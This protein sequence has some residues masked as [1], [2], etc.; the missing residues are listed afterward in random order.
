MGTG[1][2]FF[3]RDRC[4]GQSGGPDTPA[5]DPAGLDLPNIRP[6]TGFDLPDIWPDTGFDLPETR[7][8]T[9]FDLP[10][11]WPDTGNRRLTMDTGTG[12]YRY[13]DS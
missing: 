8:D 12:T 1:S 3:I 4:N 6:D 5:F 7:P 9:G 10:D 11:I 2:V 13:N